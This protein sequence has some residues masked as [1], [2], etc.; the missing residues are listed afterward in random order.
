MAI[1]PKDSREEFESY[2]KEAYGASDEFFTLDE[3]GDYESE[4][5]HSRWVDWQASDKVAKNRMLEILKDNDL[6]EHLVKFL[7]DVKAQDLNT[8][9]A[10]DAIYMTIRNKINGV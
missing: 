4:T 5:I 8:T 7:D 9:I 1:I 3:D 10:A 6:R 2:T